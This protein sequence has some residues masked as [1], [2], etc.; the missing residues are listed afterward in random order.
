MPLDDGV[1][2]LPDTLT[3]RVIRDDALYAGLR[4]SMDA[5]IATAAVKLRL[6]VNFGDPVTPAPQPIDLPPLRPN[7]GPIRI[8]GYPLETVLAER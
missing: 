2:F 1:M 5:H 3:T 7:T 6:D 4:V 8:L